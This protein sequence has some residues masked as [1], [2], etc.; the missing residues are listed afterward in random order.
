M[1]ESQ[2]PSSP[3]IVPGAFGINPARNLPSIW[4]TVI[5]VIEI[6]VGSFGVLAYGCGGTL[7]PV[8]QSFMMNMMKQMKQQSNPIMDAQSAVMAKYQVYQ[9]TNALVLAAIAIILIVAGIALVKRR[10]W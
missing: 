7:G 4:P 2:P 3:P 8:M 10:R 6:V 5:G 9:I 1:L